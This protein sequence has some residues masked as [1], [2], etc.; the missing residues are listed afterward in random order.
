MIL[1]KPVNNA[2]D[3]ILNSH[4]VL[5]RILYQCDKPNRISTNIKVVHLHVCM[6]IMKAQYLPVL[7]A[8]YAIE[9][10]YNRE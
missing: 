5:S 4:P 6:L 2:Q 1:Y 7:L 9:S 10:N 8:E 3:C